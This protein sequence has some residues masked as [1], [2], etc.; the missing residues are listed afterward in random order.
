MN[1]PIVQ[2]T[3]QAVFVLIF[4]LTLVDFLRRRTL[5]R[6]EIV[7]LFG[8]LTVV[9]IVSGIS[10]LVGPNAGALGS[11]GVFVFLAQPYLLLRLVEHFRPV[12]RLQHAIGLVG[13]L[14]SWVVAL[15][16]LL[17]LPRGQ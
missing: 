8:C 2:F 11:V 14:G 17:T 13:L 12:P 10:R 5:P 1:D 6:L 7:L 4:V 3:T 15:L 16:A 9:I